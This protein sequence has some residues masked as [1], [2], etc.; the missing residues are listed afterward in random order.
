MVRFKQQGIA[1]ASFLLIIVGAI[2]LFWQAVKLAPAYLENYRVK[3]VLESLEQEPNLDKLSR[4]KLMAMIDE[5]L[6]SAK[7]KS[8]SGDDMIVTH[9]LER[10]VVEIDYRAEVPFLSNIGFVVH[11]SEQVEIIH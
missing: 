7:V 3:A 5:R 1:S 6:I 9:G 10:T 8:V 11:F 4:V 2:I